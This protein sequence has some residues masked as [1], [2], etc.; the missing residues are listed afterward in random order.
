[1]MLLIL[2]NNTKLIRRNARI[3]KIYS[4][5]LRR[6]NKWSLKCVKCVLKFYIL[7]IYNFA[8]IHLYCIK[9]SL[10][11]NT[12]RC[13]FSLYGNSF[14]LSKL[15]TKKAIN[16]KLLGFVIYVKAII[17]LLSYSFYECNFKSGSRHL[18]TPKQK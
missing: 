18:L 5:K 17:Y 2:T 3:V 15:K 10:L 16:T 6:P 1:M 11:S 13:L 4:C 9:N 8:V 7:A 12:F 14:R